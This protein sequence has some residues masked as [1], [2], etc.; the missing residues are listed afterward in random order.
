MVKKLLQRLSSHF[1][2]TLP[3]WNCPCPPG[4]LL[5]QT[6]CGLPS[7]VRLRLHFFHFASTSLILHSLNPAWSLPPIVS[8]NNPDTNKVGLARCIALRRH[9]SAYRLRDRP[10]SLR[11]F[12]PKERRV[13][14]TCDVIALSSVGAKK[15]RTSANDT[16]ATRSR[17]SAYTRLI[18][19]SSIHLMIIKHY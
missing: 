19:L 10:S 18:V 11:Q 12:M 8:F 6:S 15:H 2:W 17:K 9:W 3:L 4:G 1:K 16:H 14:A 13:T 5:I 7:Q